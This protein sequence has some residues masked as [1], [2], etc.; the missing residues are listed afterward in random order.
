MKIQI[1]L[2]N[3]AKYT[4]GRENGEWLTLPK[5]EEKLA[6]VFERIVGKGNEHIILDYDAPFEIGE[7]EN[8]FALNEFLIDITLNGV[9]ERTVNILSKVVDTQEE[10]K[11][12]LES[13]RYII[14]NV[15]EHIQGWSTN[16]VDD[17]I[18]GRV[19]HNLGFNTVFKVKVPE[20]MEDYIDWESVYRDLSINDGWYDVRRNETDYLVRILRR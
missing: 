10:L 20:E 16:I 11:E 18:R 4:E 7:Y 9:T 15:D 19:L 12:I 2:S 6:E 17:D 13:E 5:S 3:L 14:I 8:V 1:Y